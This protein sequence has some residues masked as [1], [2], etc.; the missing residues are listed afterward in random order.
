MRVIGS[1]ASSG[2]VL[3]LDYDKNGNP[4]SIDDGTSEEMQYEY[5]R[6]NRLKAVTETSGFE[7]SYDYGAT[8]SDLRIQYNDRTSKT[9]VFS[10]RSTR[11]P[12]TAGDLRDVQHRRCSSIAAFL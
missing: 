6:N 5:D 4:L 10:S 7:D 12:D 8:E 11:Y 9:V 1:S 3:K 2:Q